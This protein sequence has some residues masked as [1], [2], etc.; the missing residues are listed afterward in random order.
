MRPLLHI[1]RRLV[2]W[3]EPEEALGDRYRFIAQIMTYGDLEDTRTMLKSYSREELLQVLDSPPPGVFT[4]R[5][6][7]FWH[8]YLNKKPRQLPGRFSATQD[9]TSSGPKMPDR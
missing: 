7:S 6:W 5:A 3:K 4:P 9:T 8:V 1:A 2:W